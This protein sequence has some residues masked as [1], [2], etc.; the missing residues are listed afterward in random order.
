M[1][2]RILNCVAAHLSELS[3]H[4]SKYTTVHTPT[5]SLQRTNTPVTKRTHAHKG[6]IPS[7]L[8]TQTPGYSFTLLVPAR[9][10]VTLQKA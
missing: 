4:S 3:L 7:F 8:I 6:M 2:E 1:A 10:R 5:Q 9:A